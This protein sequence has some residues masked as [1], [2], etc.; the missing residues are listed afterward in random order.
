[1][2]LIFDLSEIKKQCESMTQKAIEQQRIYF[3]LINA[4][5]E[6]QQNYRIVKNY[7]ISDHI[8]D[9]LKDCGV[10]IIQGTSGYQY[11][12]IPSNLK[13]KQ[14]NDTWTIEQ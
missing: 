14:Y 4:M 11:D 7:E 2:S 12:E 1:M 5:V 9:I 6:M 10:K 8:R 13:G 3:N